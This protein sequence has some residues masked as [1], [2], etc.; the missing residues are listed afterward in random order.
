MISWLMLMP[1]GAL[2]ASAACVG[3]AA[4]G[5]VDAVGVGLDAAERAGDAVYGTDDDR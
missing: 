3:G 4:V 5:L 1:D 2:A